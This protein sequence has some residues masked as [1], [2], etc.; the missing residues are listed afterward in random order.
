MI[1]LMLKIEY[2]LFACYVFSFLGRF[3][4]ERAVLACLSTSYNTLCKCLDPESTESFSTF[5][6]ELYKS[7]EGEEYLFLLCLTETLVYGERPISASVYLRHFVR[8]LSKHSFKY[9]F[10]CRPFSL[11]V[12]QALRQNFGLSNEHTT[13]DPNSSLIMIPVKTIMKKFDAHW[14]WLPPNIYTLKG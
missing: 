3:S 2:W 14:M 8:C 13:G 1:T 10:Y 12:Q 6:L 11:F 5:A 4:G 7:L 9:D